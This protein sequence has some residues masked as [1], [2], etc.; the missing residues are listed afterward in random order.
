MWFFVFY[1]WFHANHNSEE[2]LE[3]LQISQNQIAQ[4]DIN[5]EY[6]ELLGPLRDLYIQDF[7]EDDMAIRCR[8]EPRKIGSDTG[9][10]V[11]EFSFEN[12]NLLRDDESKIEKL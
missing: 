1:W 5:K 8:I 10:E 7:F 3:G 11:S 2:E 4:F 9:V 6:E 12:N